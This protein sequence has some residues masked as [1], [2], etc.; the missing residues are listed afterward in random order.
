MTPFD[1]DPPFDLNDEINELEGRIEDLWF[2]IDEI[3]F[4]KEEYDISL[5]LDCLGV[6]ASIL[7]AYRDYEEAIQ[8]LD[9]IELLAFERRLLAKAVTAKKQRKYVFSQSLASKLYQ[10]ATAYHKKK[11]KAELTQA[12]IEQVQTYLNNALSSV[13]MG[14]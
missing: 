11:Q 7:A 12:S 5:W 13:L 10:K 1:E 8:L 4:S 14:S 9:A 3:K 2:E 6:K